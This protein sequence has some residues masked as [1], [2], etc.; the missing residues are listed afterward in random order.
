MLTIESRFVDDIVSLSDEL[1]DRLIG[2]Y[3]PKS[4]ALLYG[5]RMTKQRAR[6]FAV[7]ALAE[8][9]FINGRG[10]PVNGILVDPAHSAVAKA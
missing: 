1:G 5:K 2:R 9:Q 8:E 6:Y 4:L 3:L 7:K 10:S